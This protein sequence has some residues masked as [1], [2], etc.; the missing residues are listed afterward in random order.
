MDY[1]TRAKYFGRSLLIGLTL[2]CGLAAAEIPRRADDFV[3]SIGINLHLDISAPVYNESLIG[4]L[5]LRHFRS[6]V[7]PTSTATLLNRL[8]SLYANYGTRVNIICDSTATTPVQYRDLMK[9]AMFESIEGLNEPD[10]TARSYLSLTDNAAAQSYPATRSF[11]QDLFNAMS[12]DPATVTKTVLSPAMSNPA[13]SVYLQ[14]IAA[15]V[16]A[17]H[18]YPAQ[19]MPTGGLLTS[20]VMPSAQLMA[21]PGSGVMSLIASET[22]YQGGGVT[23]GIS[24]LAAAK[25]IP[26][27]FAEYFR[28]GIAQTYLYEIVDRAGSTTFGLLD[29]AFGY[30]PAY[31][32]V[33]NL[34]GLLGEA[35]WNTAQASWTSPAAF[36]PGVLDYTISGGAASVHHVLLQKSNGAF[37]LLLWQ[38]VPSYDPTTH[39]DISNPTVPVTLAFNLT[40]TS[41]AL[42]N[43]QSPTPIA[44]YGLTRT[45]T[46]NVP[47]EVVVL[48]LTPGAAP[49]LADPIVSIKATNP[50]ATTA[51]F[52]SGLFTVT[53]TGSTASPLQVF[54]SLGG[55][56]VNGV[57]FDA[58]AGS[59]QIPAGLASAS[60]VVAPRNL[61]MVGRKAVILT[62][63]ANAAYNIATNSSSTVFINANRSVIADFETGTL[64]WSGNNRSTVAWDTANPDTGLGALKWTYSD[65]DIDRWA[66]SIKFTF[67][68][69]QDWSAVSCIE[70]RV[71]ENA[72]NPAADIGKPV[73]FT[74][75]NNGV[76]VGA[77]YGVGKFPLTHE[78]GYRTI[79]LDLREFPRDKMTALSFY[80]DGNV[81][82]AGSH[83][84]D[85]DNITAVTDSS[86][87]LD[88]FEQY[89]A[90]NWS[91]S[92]HSALSADDLNADSGQFALKWVY[93]DDGISRWGN[94]IRLNFPQPRDLSRYSTLSLRFKEDPANPLAD[95]GGKIYFDWSNNG[96][97]AS[98]G[99][100]VASYALKSA[101][102]YRTVE[103]SLAEFTRDRV[104]YLFFYLDGSTLVTGKHTW[105]LDNVSMY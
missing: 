84:F 25:Y 49:V 16:I 93:T 70:L 82:Q 79:A 38:E 105:Y 90:G 53:R 2:H 92:A 60:V 59:V 7:K 30:K 27:T 75:T 32:T 36:S 24:N 13:N 42:Y 5:G 85:I 98:N 20:Y 73:Y 72:A 4:G 33:K 29:S 88:D 34:V 3:D 47:D 11:Q 95:T 63:A 9:G 103:L 54:Y 74:W 15:D 68:A 48:Q 56:G 55:S 89:G 83:V 96:V 18:S 41:A 102:G 64:G 51:P 26:R 91:G 19:L 76:Q 94:A 71:K 61:L 58:L 23:V 37:Y 97:G 104:N 65:N 77:G 50:S 80:V 52:Q 46:V 8:T 66:N 21:S 14:G 31:T 78:A 40:I 43:L 22:G 28:L 86:G 17:M 35:T 101:A 81:L 67:P 57:D 39:L 99:S 6:N 44:S 45:L 69:A 12:S 100:G 1:T 62:L 10:G 87:N